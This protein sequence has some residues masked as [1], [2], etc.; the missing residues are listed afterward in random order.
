MLYNDNTT[1]PSIQVLAVA[2]TAFD[3]PDPHCA[4]LHG[5]ALLTLQPTHDDVQLSGMVMTGERYVDDT[6]LIA[7]LD[8]ALDPGAVLAGIDLT[9][10]LS[11]LGRLPIEMIDQAP[12]L[13]L[14]GKLKAM[15]ENHDPIDL[16]INMKAHVALAVKVIEHKLLLRDKPDDQ[17]QGLGL[18]LFASP[19]NLNTNYLAAELADTV[20]AAALAIGDLCLEPAHAQPLLEA[21]RQW[22]Q[23]LHARWQFDPA[24]IESVPT[25]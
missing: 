21:W 3:G 10:T 2:C 8:N 25:I 16:T 18:R 17:D 13:A 12:S 19:G 22:R 6:R 14:L 9:S 5:Y 20:G 24:T 11:L 4:W 23:N 7:A 15:L 1:R